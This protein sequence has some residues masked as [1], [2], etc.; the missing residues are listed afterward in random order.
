MHK[1]VNGHIHSQVHGK[2][3]HYYVVIFI[4]VESQLKDEVNSL[5]QQCST[6]D[7]L[8][9][10]M[11]SQEDDLTAAVES[12]DSQIHILR[13]RLQESDDLLKVMKEEASKEKD[14]L[15]LI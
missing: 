6:L 9:R 3:T 8:L 1:T 11:R 10:R 4:A 12:R 15:D 13:T 7:Q 5:R 14:R 2:W